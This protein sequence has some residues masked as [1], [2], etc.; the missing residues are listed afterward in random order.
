MEERE[1]EHA[2]RIEEA[3][4]EEGLQRAR[5]RQADYFPLWDG[6][7]CWKCGEDLPPER[8]SA[9][10]VFCVEHQRQREIQGIQP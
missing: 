5:R 3:M 10:R 2:S 6:V 8:A 7:T 4:R 9:G 1:F